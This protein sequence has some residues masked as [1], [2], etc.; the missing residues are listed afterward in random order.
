MMCSAQ[1]LA[2]LWKQKKKT[3]AQGNVFPWFITMWNLCIRCACPLQ[4]TSCAAGL[5]VAV[6]RWLR[7]LFNT[8]LPCEFEEAVMSCNW[9]RIIIVWI[10]QSDVRGRRKLAHSQ[11]QW[12]Q[13]LGAL[14]EAH[15]GLKTFPYSLAFFIFFALLKSIAHP[16]NGSHIWWWTIVYY[17]G[18]I[19][20]ILGLRQ[21]GTPCQ[22]SLRWWNMP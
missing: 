3:P 4:Y 8:A 7:G 2:A 11:N 22:R 18:V 13:R 1:P 14:A 6:C 21:N 10:P 12:E 9:G 16:T 17:N 5:A 15:N 19:V 20:V